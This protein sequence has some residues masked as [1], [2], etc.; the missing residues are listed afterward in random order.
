MN[1]TLTISYATLDDLDAMANLLSVLLEQEADF[2]PDTELQKKGLGM[3]LESPEKGILLI[4]KINNELV[5]MVN[6][7]FTVSTA[8][9]AKVAI[10]EDMIVHPNFRNREIGKLLIQ[11]ATTC[12]NE[13][14]CKRI[15]LLTD[16]DNTKAHQFYKNNGF[17]QSNMLAFRISL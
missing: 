14:G 12:A 6:L 15:T 2:S 9:G 8:L 11:K 7:L 17:S 10:L 3:I 16:H 4:A 5:G 1:N 13:M